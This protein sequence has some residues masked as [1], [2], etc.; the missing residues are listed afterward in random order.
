MDVFPRKDLKHFICILILS[1]S[2]ANVTWITSHVHISLLL[3][4]VCHLVKNVSRI[5][6]ILNMISVPLFDQVLKQI[7]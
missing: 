4:Y 6:T 2:L 3:Q 7:E 5:I 1:V